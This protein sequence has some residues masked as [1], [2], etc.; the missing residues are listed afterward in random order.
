MDKLGCLM[1]L[2]LEL[3]FEVS[4]SIII[5]YLAQETLTNGDKAK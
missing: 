4:T 2:I 5:C 3:I 1:V